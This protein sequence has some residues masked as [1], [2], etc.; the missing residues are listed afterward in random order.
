MKKSFSIALL[1]SLT[2]VLIF[3]ISECAFSQDVSE[4]LDTFMTTLYN[5][6]LFNGSVL[7]AVKGNV[8]YKNAFGK[9]DF[10][11]SIDFKTETPCYLASLTKQF[12]AMAIMMLHEKGKINYEDKLSKYFDGFPSYADKITL[13]NLLNHT[14]GIP[15]YFYLGTV[16][17]GFTNND[18]LGTLKKQDSL[19]FNPG[20]KFEYSNSGYVLLSMVIEKISG[21]KYGDCEKKY[22]RTSE[23]E[24]YF[25]FRCIL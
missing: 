3:F 16:H 8:L 12:T 22:F 19:N 9:A 15:D 7:V 6:G 4:K 17:P 1:K 20:D 2:P 21:M 13:R 23:Y 14:S 11:K 25:C 5:R 24:K 10:Y 18:V